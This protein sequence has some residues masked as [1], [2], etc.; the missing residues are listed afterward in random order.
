M[1]AH[2]RASVRRLVSDPVQASDPRG[3]GTHTHKDHAAFIR[4]HMAF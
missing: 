3:L 4:I 1:V 2:L